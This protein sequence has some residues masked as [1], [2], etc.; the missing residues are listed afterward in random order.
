M[1]DFD[2]DA[3]RKSR[4]T[5]L[6]PAAHPEEAQ[7]AIDSQPA[8]S[9]TPS[10]GQFDMGAFRQQRAQN[11]MQSSQQ[12]LAD[13]VG[14]AP[15][16]AIP[17]SPL[18]PIERGAF[19]WTDPSKRQMYL[20]Q[21]FGEGNVELQKMDKDGS[22][23]VVRGKDGKWYQVDPAGLSDI[24]NHFVPVGS[25]LQ[26]AQQGYQ[27]SGI[28]GALTGAASA[29]EKNFSPS[30]GVSELMNGG[31]ND[32][33]GGAAQFIGEHGSEAAG[34]AAAAAPTAE[35]GAEAGFLGGGPVG[36]LAGGALG[37]AM[38]AVG[39]KAVEDG[40]RDFWY[41]LTKAFGGKTAN[42]NDPYAKLVTPD[43]F[44]HQINS[45]LLFG[46]EQEL[47]GPMMKAGLEGSAKVLGALG[48]RI[49]DTPEGQT[50]LSGLIS[51]IGQVKKSAADTFA[52]NSDAV[53]SYIPQAVKDYYQN[54][55]VLYGRMKLQVEDLYNQLLAKRGE[56]GADFQNIQDAAKG[57]RFDP[58]VATDAGDNQLLSAWKNLQDERYIDQAGNLA[59][60]VR[61]V[62][63]DL[64]DTNGRALQVAVNGFQKLRQLGPSASY[65]DLQIYKNNLD[66]YIWGKNA[67]SDGKL[68]GILKDMRNGVMDAQQSGL[69]KVD[70]DL[71]Q[72]FADLNNKYGPVKDLLEQMG[73]KVDG[74]RLDTFLKRTLK[75]D[76][77]FDNGLL[78]AVSDTVGDP[79]AV[80]RI[81]QMDSARAFAP[82]FVGPSFGHSWSLPASPRF[83]AGVGDALG[84]LQKGVSAMQQQASDAVSKP[85]M[86]LHDMYKGLD[87]ATR[88]SLIRSPEALD[89]LGRIFSGAVV[90][91]QQKRQQ[92]LQQSGSFMQSQFGG[93]GNVNGGL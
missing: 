35:A 4:Q 22:N 63:R 89:S 87:D 39:G 65:Q 25:A 8:D 6:E 72:Q 69:E 50:A 13:T 20:Q 86:A 79:D 76:G 81:L 64:T 56:Y 75:G 23:Y 55:D 49:A 7:K 14:S 91:E 52:R 59:P 93:G 77:S 92:L 17:H 24:A 29:A 57:K 68:S 1:A 18:S 32:A 51:T 73:K 28:L 2:M 9:P 21:K 26:G 44:G 10:G 11:L 40:V 85:M 47:A 53:S 41:G 90:G 66:N 58:F 60:D 5:N 38:G 82:A 88:G 12:V 34:A 37:G 30:Q 54:S 62:G 16:L 48:K 19:G 83:A 3:W 15:Q 46:A 71:A 80:N 27:R 36:A 43:D 67:I 74:S 61:G 45:S 84:S 70:P 78:Q 33:A 42:E 31:L